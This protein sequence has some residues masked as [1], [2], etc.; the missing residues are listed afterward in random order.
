VNG[1]KLAVED[2]DTFVDALEWIADLPEG[3]R[4]ALSKAAR[5]TARGMS[6]EATAEKLAAVYG[7]VVRRKPAWDLPE[8]NAWQSAMRRIGAEWKLL[9]TIAHAAG[10]ALVGAEAAESAAP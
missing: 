9:G 5:G 3:A 10:T 1:R 4:K 6:L 7:S 2:T 8:E